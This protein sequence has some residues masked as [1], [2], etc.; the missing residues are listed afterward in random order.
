[1]ILLAAV[2]TIAII[3]AYAVASAIY[4]AGESMDNE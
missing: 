2:M 4:K 3:L 1:M